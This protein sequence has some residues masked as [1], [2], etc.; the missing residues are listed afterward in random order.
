MKKLGLILIAVVLSACGSDDAPTMPVQSNPEELKKVWVWQSG[1]YKLT[2]DN[3]AGDKLDLSGITFDA[4]NPS[5]YFEETALNGSAWRTPS[6]LSGEFYFSSVDREITV[7]LFS[8]LI[9]VDCTAAPAMPCN[10]GGNGMPLSGGPYF[11]ELRYVA[12]ESTLEICSDNFCG[13]Y[14]AL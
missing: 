12:T 8:N 14:R 9:Y 13:I 10:Q 2:D 4:P 7:A 11:G 1:D 5:L 3:E 6:F